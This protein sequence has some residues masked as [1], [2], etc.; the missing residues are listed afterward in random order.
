[1]SEAIKT[2]K[3]IVS[4]NGETYHQRLEL[5]KSGAF[6]YGNGTCVEYYDGLNQRPTMYDTRYETGIV[7]NFENWAD[8]FI[9][10]LCSPKCEIV[11]EI[12]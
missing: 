6:D 1:M 2:R 4:I 10:S 8:E 7:G 9:K 5:H 11:C 12:Q 3:Y